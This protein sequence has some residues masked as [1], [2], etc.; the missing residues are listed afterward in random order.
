MASYSKEVMNN[1]PVQYYTFSGPSGNIDMS[2]HNHDIS[3]TGS[4]YITSLDGI[5]IV[6]NYYASSVLIDNLPNPVNCF[7][8]KSPDNLFTINFW[9]HP[10]A[11]TISYTPTQVFK[12]SGEKI[13]SSFD[14]TCYLE[15][16][17]NSYKLVIVEPSGKKNYASVDNIDINSPCQ[18]SI[19]SN[20]NDIT[21]IVNNKMGKKIKLSDSFSYTESDTLKINSKCISNLSIFNKNLTS[22]AIFAMLVAGIREED[23]FNI[24]SEDAGIH[25]PMFK[26]KISIGVDGQV[27]QYDFDYAYTNNLIVDKNGYITFKQYENIKYTDLEGIDYFPSISSNKATVESGKF[28]QL[29]NIK[30]ML[31]YDVGAVRV[32]LD[33]GLN[34]AKKQNIFAISMNSDTYSYNWYIDT[35]NIL[36]VDEII[37]G[38]SSTYTYNLSG[39]NAKTSFDFIFYRDN[40]YVVTANT[41]SPYTKNI[42]QV[43]LN[44]VDLVDSIPTIFLV[45][46]GS[47][48]RFGTLDDL[49]GGEPVLVSDIIFYNYL[50]LT[51]SNF[52]GVQNADLV[53]DYYIG[54]LTKSTCAYTFY[55][56]SNANKPTLGPRV[57][58]VMQYSVPL[59]YDGVYDGSFVEFDLPND[60]DSYITTVYS[61]TGAT[62]GTLGATLYNKYQLTSIN[63]G[64]TL[65]SG[66]L[67]FNVNLKTQDLSYHQPK[68]SKIMYG[69]YIDPTGNFK[70]EN[71]TDLIYTDNAKKYFTNQQY[72]YVMFSD[73]SSG[74]TLHGENGLQI[75]HGP[76]KSLEFLFNA[77]VGVTGGTGCYLLYSNTATGST[78]TTGAAKY[79]TLKNT[80]TGGSGLVVKNYNYDYAYINGV[81]LSSGN[82]TTLNSYAN[83]HVI[84]VNSTTFNTSAYLNS[85]G[86]FKNSPNSVGGVVSYRNV[87]AYDYEL[88]MPQ[89][90]NHNDIVRGYK[91]I[92]LGN[93]G[94]IG[95]LETQGATLYSYSWIVQN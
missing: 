5:G 68:F 64:G 49:L 65:G 54:D 46:E 53:S 22:D 25:Y 92:S 18:I 32:S 6:P 76:N 38:L 45:S 11:N 83:H 91:K 20:G 90:T 29:S 15:C 75:P 42:R 34:K 67:T 24:F 78:G 55:D 17:S 13:I 89:V 84:A 41:G 26:D 79:L 48:A 80:S 69:L 27:D 12:T 1:R 3:V 52:D 66:V 88:S 40:I 72:D 23:N 21:L 87:C 2:Y 51:S 95:T 16:V 9:H 50:P 86:L 4:S 28:L 73:L 33:I 47:S 36:K 94:T 30:E 37:N 62:G 61:G 43:Y 60:G 10:T 77:S 14:D 82:S 85:D 19:V 8:S 70:S 93:A 71:H 56:D 58:G 39:L 31:G 59:I 7:S 81:T 44:G 35:D 74:V 63:S 57:Q